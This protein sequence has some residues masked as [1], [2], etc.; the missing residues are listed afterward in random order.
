MRIGVFGG[1][2]NPPHAGH[3]I[4]AQEALVKLGLDLVAFVPV[5]DPPH[6]ELDEDPGAEA[7]FALCE[8]AVAGDERFRVSRVEI[9][10][11]GKSYTVDTLR[12]LRESE[13]TDEL[14]LILGGD[15]A[16]AL[17]SWRDPAEVARL[18]AA[19]GVA[20]RDPVTREA[21][22]ARLGDVPG[23]AQKL[24]FFDMPRI[25]ISSTL[26]R[27]RAAEGAPLRYLVPDE[28][29]SYIGAH[30]LYGASTPAAGAAR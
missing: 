12:A 6:R 7:R 1:A 29:A 23:A 21:V 9:D 14:V 13:P 30:G 5:G 8:C 10:R 18:A 11:G 26:V 16:L 24:A 28:V 4:C 25:D 15:Q 20:E 22:E 2:F 3:L 27:R 19:I 17:P